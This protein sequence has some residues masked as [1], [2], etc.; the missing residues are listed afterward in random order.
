[1]KQVLF[2]SVFC[3]LV[4]VRGGES[5]SAVSVKDLSELPSLGVIAAKEGASVVIRCNASE[6][7]EHIEW[8]DSEGRVLSGNDSRG[9]R[10]T[11]D[12]DTLNITSVS[13]EDRGR[14]TCISRSSEGISNYTV[15]L[16]VSYTSSGLGLY[17]II[18][19]FITFT[20][21]IILNMT[22]LCMINTHLRKTERAINDFFRT[23][24]AEKLQKA[25]EIAK[26]I[27][28]VTSAKTVELAKVT[29][30]KTLELAKQMEELARS[31]PLPPLILTCTTAVDEAECGGPA[32]I[33]HQ[34]EEHSEQDALSREMRK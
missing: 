3:V 12:K 8:Y 19:C 28:I 27:P 20:I 7:H 21:T 6:L 32:A 17:Y 13:F 23:D 15:T 11:V 24:G 14:Y 31:V 9:R 33:E 34:E 10:V 4:C 5:V 1:M 2:L 22:R 30:F 29:Q 25:L 16:R 26:R 18:V